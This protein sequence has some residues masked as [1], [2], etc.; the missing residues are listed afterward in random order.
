MYPLRHIA[1]VR[2]AYFLDPLVRGWRPR[3][4]TVVDTVLCSDVVLPVSIGVKLK[5]GATTKKAAS[6]SAKRAVAQNGNPGPER[7][8]YTQLKSKASVNMDVVG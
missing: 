3:S 5:R 1:L 8:S 6:S 2:K 4:D 7:R